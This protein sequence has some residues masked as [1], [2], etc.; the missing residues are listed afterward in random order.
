M[1]VRLKMS[2]YVVQRARAALIPRLS[3][4]CLAVNSLTKAPTLNWNT[5]VPAFETH[6]LLEN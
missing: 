3:H 4:T 5:G 2:W 6:S 1:N